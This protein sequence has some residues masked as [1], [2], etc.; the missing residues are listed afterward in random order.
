MFFTTILLALVS[1]TSSVAAGKLNGQGVISVHQY[2]QTGRDAPNN[3]PYCGY[4]WKT[5]NLN[6]ITA[7]QDLTQ[8]QC[9]TCLEIC[10]S[11]GCITMLAVDRGG[12]NLDMSTGVSKGIIGT[13][14][15][16]AEAKWRVVPSKRCQGI[17]HKRKSKICEVIHNP[18]FIM[19]FFVR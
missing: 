14:D 5:L 19:L 10:G 3:P 15:G 18:T 7:V 16:I 8:N 12:R 17:R 2:P 11:G 13:N 6:R 1:L 4:P 9:G